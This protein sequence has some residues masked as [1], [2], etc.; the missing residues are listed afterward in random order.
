[1]R[2]VQCGERR[3]ACFYVQR[4][5]LLR[6]ARV[7]S[8][9]GILKWVSEV[10]LA[11]MSTRSAT[12]VMATFF[13]VS[14]HRAR[15]STWE[16]WGGVHCCA[17]HGTD[18]NIPLSSWADSR[19]S[20]WRAASRGCTKKRKVGVTQREQQPSTARVCNENAGRRHLLGALVPRGRPQRPTRNGG[21]LFF[22][23]RLF[24]PRHAGFRALI[25]HKSS[26]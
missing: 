7:S 16:S 11:C 5:D 24:F 26:T 14:C 23:K 25:L 10:G 21:M 4:L 9:T 1:M 17:Y 3:V 13:V 19:P 8:K 15:C 12:T 20:R 18:S 6:V 22:W 2:G